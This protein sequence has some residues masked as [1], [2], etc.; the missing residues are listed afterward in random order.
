MKTVIQKAID[1]LRESPNVS[2][3]NESIANW[4]ETL[5]TEEKSQIINA[6]VDGTITTIADKMKTSGESYYY[7]KYVTEIK[8]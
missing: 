6:F 3:S 7:K 4:L 8:K 5:L 2:Y 1:S